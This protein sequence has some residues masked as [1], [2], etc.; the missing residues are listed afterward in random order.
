MMAGNLYKTNLDLRMR[1]SSVQRSFI[2]RHI[3]QLRATGD[4]QAFLT[5]SAGDDLTADATAGIDTNAGRMV[6]TSAEATVERALF[7]TLCAF[8]SGLRAPEGKAKRGGK[9]TLRG[10]FK[11]Q[12]AADG[13]VEIVF[14][15]G[16]ALSGLHA[17]SAEL[18]TT[19]Q[20]P[21]FMKFVQS[22][23]D[24]K[25]TALFSDKL[26]SV[27]NYIRRTMN[28][29]A[30]QVA[31]ARM[32][33]AKQHS[34]VG[35]SDGRVE[36]MKARLIRERLAKQKCT[37]KM[38]REQLRFSDAAVQLQSVHQR[39]K[40]ELEEIVIAERDAPPSSA[41]PSDLKVLLADV[42]QVLSLYTAR[43]RCTEREDSRL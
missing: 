39:A 34:R 2:E 12:T 20:I 30:E 41:P 42:I 22:R 43:H 26:A 25:A 32:Q 13:L 24:E 9:P 8:T 40:D 11:A 31:E 14:E 16:D 4:A 28:D 19:L 10:K 3:S 6:P 21:I 35:N 33:L 27:M 37:L 29:M 36:K 23:G 17:D 15:D 7:D 5:E 18:L 38:V 1:L